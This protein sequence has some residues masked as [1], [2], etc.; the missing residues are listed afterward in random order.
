M[1][2]SIETISALLDSELERALARLRA[3]RR[4]LKADIE[5]LRAEQ[6]RRKERR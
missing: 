3:A 6:A 2:M 5:A 4:D 1:S